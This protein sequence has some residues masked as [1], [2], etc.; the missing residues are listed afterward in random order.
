MPGPALRAGPVWGRGGSCTGAAP[1]HHTRFQTVLHLHICWIAQFFKLSYIYLLSSPGNWYW[2]SRHGP[3]K[4]AK[5]SRW[6]D[7][8]TRQTVYAELAR[9]NGSCATAVTSAKSAT[10]RWST[11]SSTH[12]D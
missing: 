11:T 6:T 7:L 4:G 8:R 2:S 5:R 9:R 12:S 3:A 10:F 1:F